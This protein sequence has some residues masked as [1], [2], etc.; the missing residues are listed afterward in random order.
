M[1]IQQKQKRKGTPRPTCKG[2]KFAF[3]NRGGRPR[4]WKDDTIAIE[5]AA[6]RDWMK[7]PENYF[8]TNFLVQRG[9]CSEH[10]NRLSK[11]SEEF[12]ETLER[13]R[14]VQECRLVEMGIYRK[15]D[16]GFIKFILQNK[17]GWK[18]KNEFSGDGTNPL[19]V[20]MDRI[21]AN[22]KDPLDC[23]D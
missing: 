9:L 4:E 10:L 23:C 2:N 14:L 20:I 17:A 7:N 15:G 19:A 16:P 5:E 1:T 13:A 8:L 12:R 22:S 11:Y 21:A 18:E 6:L 3:G